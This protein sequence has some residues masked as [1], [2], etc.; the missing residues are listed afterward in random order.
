MISN[1]S[2]DLKNELDT[3]AFVMDTNCFN[4]INKILDRMIELE[5][6]INEKAD[7][8]SGGRTV[9]YSR[10]SEDYRYSED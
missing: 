5:N 6:F 1:T 9:I 10:Y 7:K 8:V 2:R 4:I 3:Y